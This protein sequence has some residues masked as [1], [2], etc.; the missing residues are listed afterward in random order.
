MQQSSSRIDRP[1][2]SDAVC[3]QVYIRSFAD[4]GADGVGDLAGILSR[5]GYLELLGVDAL[6]ITPCYPSPM[7]D[8]GYDVADPR[9]IDPLFGDLA[10]F[11]ALVAASHEHGIR[12]ILDLVPN[13]TSDEHEW[14]QAAVRAAPGSPERDRYLFRYGRGQDGTEPPNNW[15][16]QFGG[17]AWTRIIE[18]HGQLGQWY[19]HLFAPEQPDLNWENPEVWADLEK[20]LRFWLERDVDGFRIDVAHGLAKPAGLPDGQDFGLIQAGAS[21]AAGSDDEVIVEPDKQQPDARFD[22]DGVHDVHRMIRA[23]TDE[24]RD[25]VL[26]G[27]IWVADDERFSH[28]LRPDELHL[29]FNFRLTTAR[30]DAAEIREAIEHSMNAVASVGAPPTWTLSNHD[31]PRPVTRFGGGPVG[32]ARAR[33]LALVELGLPGVIFLYNGEELGLPSVELP[34]E[35]LQDPVWERSGRTRRGRDAHRVPMPWEGDA[36]PFGFTESESPWLP[37]PPDWR[38]LTVETQLEDA[39]STLSLYRHA[40]EIRR[41]H[42][43]FVG[44]SLEWYGAPEGCFAYR[45]P[46]TTMVCALNTSAAPVQLPPG[47]VLLSSGPLT[48]DGKLPPDTAVWLA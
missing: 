38:A 48:E 25:R 4:A 41:T 5:L 1:W 11:D 37:M 6:W 39:G 22:H 42:P 44:D 36:P 19:L 29:G 31:V 40:L 34:D 46:G 15:P 14:F 7:A 43:G 23:V 30:F 8:H 2:W 10:T 12:V 47:D 3:Y 28:Y 45:R 16:S 32:T 9:D 17:P 35:V 33:A 13:H 21:G 27:E 20:T 18:P 24:Y 26:L